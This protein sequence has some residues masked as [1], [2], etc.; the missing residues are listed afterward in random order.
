MKRQDVPLIAVAFPASHV[1]PTSDFAHKPTVDVEVIER[2]PYPVISSAGP[3]PSLFVA[4]RFNRVFETSAVSAEWVT[5]GRNLHFHPVANQ[6]LGLFG[7]V[8]CIVS[9]ILGWTKARVL[10]V[11]V[12]HGVTPNFM[13]PAH[14]I[15]QRPDVGSI[16][17]YFS[18]RSMEAVIQMLRAGIRSDEKGRTKPVLIEDGETTLYLAAESVIEGQ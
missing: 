13:P 7:F 16:P 12:R 3:R 11:F 15:F 8:S 2:I 5:E 18:P 9:S 10:R 4:C 1:F 14:H 17:F 6:A